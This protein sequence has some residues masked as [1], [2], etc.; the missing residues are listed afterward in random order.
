MTDK[1][2]AIA[3]PLDLRRTSRPGADATLA[4]KSFVVKENIDTSGHVSGNGNP[5]FA[6]TH[7]PAALDAP[8]VERLLDAGARLVGKTHMDEMAYSLLGANSH[9]GTPVNPAAPARHPG[10]SSSGSAVAVAA[11]LADF[12]LGTDTAGSCRAPAAFCG[13]FGFR[14]SHGALSS[15]GVVP[16]A[17]TLDTIGWFARDIDTLSTVGDVLLPRDLRPGPILSVAFLKE[18]FD[19]SDAEL[20]EAAKPALAALPLLFS[21]RE[22]ILGEEFWSAALTHFRNLQAYEAWRAHG[23]WIAATKPSFGPGIAERFDYAAAV[24]NEAK[25]DADAFRQTARE[26]IDD[27]LQAQS[28]IVAPTTPFAA[29]LLSESAEELDRKRYRMVRTFL[30]ASFFGLPQISIPL[31]RP[32]GAPPLA[33]SL[34]G[35]RWSDRALLDAARALIRT[36]PEAFAK[37]HFDPPPLPR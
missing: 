19:N 14:P 26:R 9:Y 2:S 37:D 6:A 32:A 15:N 27:L 23:E 24:S 4:G 31:A 5:T 35:P 1:F 33:L 16:L 22:T 21:L 7:A 10:G 34:I 18:A 28:S 25:R 8:A 11:G 30:L 36:A 13:V 17:E 12:A 29:P 3:T 20:R